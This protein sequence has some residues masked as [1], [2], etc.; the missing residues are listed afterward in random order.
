[1]PLF[2]R[3]RPPISAAEAEPSDANVP[4]SSGSGTR[5]VVARRFFS[6]LLGATLLP[7]GL[8]VWMGLQL[9][10]D[11][12]DRDAHLRA[13]EANRHFAQLIQQRLTAAQAQLL[14]LA[15]A[16]AHRGV[17]V[18]LPAA[19]PVL[20][21]LARANA[22]GQV[23][24]GPEALVQAWTQAPAP[25]SGLSAAPATLRWLAPAAGRSEARIIL[26]QPASDGT[27]WFAEVDT[28]FLRSGAQEAV[29][30]FRHCV[31]DERG[32]AISC[33]AA[34]SA[35]GTA[36]SAPSGDGQ[37]PGPTRRQLSLQADFGA[38]HWLILTTVSDPTALQADSPLAWRWLGVGALATV[39]L[40]GG[41]GW[42]QF[43][44]MGQTLNALIDGTTRLA[45]QD[46][47]TRVHLP[48]GDE[49]AR[50]GHSLNLMAERI[51]HQMKAI[52]VQ[53]AIDREILGGLDTAR[54][55]DLV[56]RRLEALA[57]QAKVAVVV[58]GQ[59]RAE[60][61]SH[62]PY[63]QPQPL[64][65][66]PEMP[67]LPEGQFALW[68]GGDEPVPT[69]ASRAL[70]LPAGSVQT[71]CWVPAVWQ[72]QM[73]ALLIMGGCNEWDL[74][75]EARREIGEL[76]DRTAVTLAA[77]AR[78]SALLE[79]AVHDG[80]TGLFNR[81][82]L[83]DGIER[84]IDAGSPFTVILVDLDRF[85]E[86]ND[87][88]GHQAG[89]ELLCA[90]AGRLRRCVTADAVIA[91]PGGDEFVL[92]L[93]GAPE[94]ASASALA[95]CAELAKPFAL[96]GVRQQIG[97]S[98]GLAAYPQHGTSRVELI[99]RADMAM[100]AA[101]S[102]GRGRLSWYDPVMDERIAERAWMAQELRRAL[103][104][105]QF[106]LHFQ[107]RVDAVSSEV[108][109][110]E[111]LVRWNHPERGMMMPTEFVP[112][113]EETGLIDRLGHWV[114]AA[115]LRQMS[116]WRAQGLPLRR[117]AVNVSP[118]QLKSNG[119]AD[120]V[121]DLMARNQLSGGDIE[122][123]LTE[124]LFSGDVDEVIRALAPLR[125]AGV[126]VALDD[127]GTGYSSLSS[128]YRLPVDVI[129]IDRSFVTDLG[130]R[131]SADA[132]ARSIVALAKALRKRVVAEGVE[133]RAQRD[134][135]L[136][137]D[138]DE[139]QGYLYAEPMPAQAL[140]RTLRGDR[141]PALSTPAES[142]ALA[143]LTLDS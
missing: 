23:M 99:R 90:V 61:L 86:V 106:E 79:R 80:L 121:L 129:K 9:L 5:G 77:A 46:W 127:F 141:M 57:P 130:K 102:G 58:I 13:T 107:P 6:V 4:V 31:A 95:I 52:Q 84:L 18:D 103:D 54:V 83:H 64:P 65:A 98:V 37:Q 42:L 67:I 114:M 100:Y 122:I 134:H 40:V 50:L 11:E 56:V 74:P 128:L 111:V 34:V 137:L 33:G 133:T 1:M 139:L 101:K 93:P 28:G 70:G 44:R 30:G 25:A 17:H 45:A 48:S 94:E 112:A 113:A 47:S 27:Q 142:P 82:G 60:W 21:A 73:L 85:K 140:E 69:W 81:N 89:D 88:L 78:E 63:A 131:E 19:G 51:G 7:I 108:V 97:G 136:R 109:C 29:A 62:R 116:L 118:R 39:L 22:Q 2:A 59:G 76:R 96:R 8:F 20:S 53:S 38:G 36:G 41:L 123:E 105:T 12:A 3:P 92:L 75:E 143:R 15:E 14:G 104:H 43:R 10:E 119:F 66:P 72:G 124:N 115:A 35:A 120:A 87:T 125:E 117:I 16:P 71:L 138:C 126:L 26:R 24:A 91:R 68:C 135:L 32:Q 49:F 132:V 110:A 55:M